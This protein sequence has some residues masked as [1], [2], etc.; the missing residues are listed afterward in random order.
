[1]EKIEKAHEAEYGVKPDVIISAPGRFHLIGEHSWFCRDKTLSMAI[2]LP[3]YVAISA[4][5]DSSLRCYFTELDDRKRANLQTMKF[6]KEDRWFN[7]VKAM[8]CGMISSGFSCK[9]MNITIHSKILPSAGFGIT[10]AIKTAVLYGCR[11]LF[12][13]Q[14]SDEMLLGCFVLGNKQFLGTATYYADVFT[15][16]Y[17]QPDTCLLTNYETKD[18]ELF[19]FNFDH[20]SVLL[21]DA[22]VPRISVWNEESVRSP[23]NILLLGELKNRKR[24][25]YGGWVYQESGSELVEVLS[26]VSEDMRKRLLSVIREHHC[27]LEAVEGLKENNFEKFAHAVNKSHDNMRDLYTISCPEIDWL[28]K[29]VLEFDLVSSL[30]PKACARI[31][32][33]GFGRCTYTM[34]KNSYVERYRNKLTEYERIFGFKPACYEI[35][36]A[37]GTKI[38]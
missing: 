2:N 19:P 23:E 30:T 7:A 15:S 29:R 9:G 20:I 22:K 21:T 1:M 32:G 8:L 31:T 28:T 16:M 34:L 25:A 17:A 14:C 5:P 35:Q 38:L 13:K 18:Y 36:S 10:T 6:K 27:V 37:G 24:N 26:V 3:V 11:E 4:R 12:A 33:K